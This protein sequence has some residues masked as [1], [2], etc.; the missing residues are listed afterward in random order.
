MGHVFSFAFRP[1]FFLAIVYGII[2]VCWWGFAWSGYLPM[3]GNGGNPILW[4]GHEMIFGFAAAAIGG[5]ALTA[6][7]NWTRRPPVSGL[8]LIA[9]CSCWLSARVLALGG[10][11]S[12]LIP[13][14][15]ADLAF[16]VLLCA[17]MAREVVA[18]GRTVFMSSHV[19]SEVQA[20]A[21]RVG[22][23]DA[24][25][26]VSFEDVDTLLASA[27]RDVEI[28]FAEPVPGAVFANLEGVSGLSIDGTVLTCRLDGAADALVKAAAAHTVVS[29]TS[30]EPDLEDLF[31]H[32]YSS[33]TSTPPAELDPPTGGHRP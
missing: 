28:H 3:P 23:I 21:D 4:H 5:F 32:R 10:S 25:V 20:T 16:D 6:V 7:A 31:F 9:L 27:T 11:E 33:P 12:L 24:G 17:L 15:T 29:F 13:T 18:D 22:I 8:P 30:E 26:L 2:S 19:L 1:L 14:A